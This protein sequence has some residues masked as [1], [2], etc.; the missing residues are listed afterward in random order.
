MP[1][2]VKTIVTRREDTVPGNVVAETPPSTPVNVQV[3]AMTMLA[4]A[5]VRA[6]R[7]YVTSLTGLLAAGGI[8]ADRGVLP[9]EFGALLW[10]SAG[11]ALAPATM[12]FLLNFGELLARLDQK[13][14]ELR[15]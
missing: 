3:I 7:A 6:C 13:I 12:S 9:D 1:E 4:Q 2:E 8:G 11:I 15:A 14:P 10:T 5:L